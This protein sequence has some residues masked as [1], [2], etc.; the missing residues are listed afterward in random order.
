[1][2][3]KRDSSPDKL[4]APDT[5][6]VMRVFPALAEQLHCVRGEVQVLLQLT[7]TLSERMLSAASNRAR[8]PNDK[9]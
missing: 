5:N 9:R 7:T 3:D 4:P 6:G 1:M 2:D 8:D